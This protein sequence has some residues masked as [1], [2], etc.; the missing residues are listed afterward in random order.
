MKTALLAA[1]ALLLA[2]TPAAAQRGGPSI[3]LYELP[4]YQG[5]S[6]SFGAD[7]SNMAD[8]G[9][10]DRAQ[11]ARVNGR[12][13]VCED[14]R[15]RGRCVELSGDVP[16]LAQVRLTAAISSIED[17]NRG[18]GFGGGYGGGNFGGGG[19]PNPGPS[20]DGRSVSFFPQPP[21]GFR[22]ADDFCRRMGFSGVVYADDR[23]VLRD[24]V[25]RR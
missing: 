20:L 4:N 10:N 19:R 21:P 18:G 2:A 1:A 7:V 16:D 14:S 12:W 9:F 24:V 11:S 15:L 17:L 25:C 22:N 23:G 6:R 13:R 3:T 8:Q 5:G